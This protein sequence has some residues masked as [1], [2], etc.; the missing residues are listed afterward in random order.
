MANTSASGDVNETN[1]DE[2]QSGRKVTVEDAFSHLERV[3]GSPSR[4]RLSGPTTLWVLG[5]I[6]AVPLVALTFF[7][8]IRG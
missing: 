2:E 4:Y 5:I 1:G 8:L 7:S 3:E 6:A